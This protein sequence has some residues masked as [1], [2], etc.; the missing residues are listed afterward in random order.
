MFRVPGGGPVSRI[1]QS[2]VRHPGRSLAIA[3][4]GTLVAYFAAALAFLWQHQP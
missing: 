3:G 4:G 2:V 1:T